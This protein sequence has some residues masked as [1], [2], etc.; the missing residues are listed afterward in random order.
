MHYQNEQSNSS[1]FRDHLQFVLDL[2]KDFGI[3]GKKVVEVGC[4]KA[5][6][7]EMMRGEGIDCWGFD[8]TY[9]G[10]DPRIK[11]E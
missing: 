2:L 4:G 8:P 6:F 9:E 11:N 5:V 1:V 3:K 10:T 7:F